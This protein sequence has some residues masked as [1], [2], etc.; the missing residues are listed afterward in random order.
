MKKRLL[1]GTLLAFAMLLFC[2][3]KSSAQI[4][5][6]DVTYFQDSSNNTGCYYNQVMD[7]GF[8]GNII[9][10]AGLNDSVDID[11]NWGDGSNTYMRLPLV[12]S[13]YFYS[14]PTHTFA[15]AGT[16]TPQV[17]ATFGT[18]SDFE[19]ANT[20]TL[21][22][23]CASLTGHLYMDVNSNCA[24]DAGEASLAWQNIMITNTTNSDVYYAYTDG[25][26]DY[27]VSVPSGITYTLIPASYYALTTTC[28]SSGTATVTVATGMSYNNDFGMDCSTIAGTDVG[29]DGWAWNWR[30]GFDR[31]LN[32]SAWSNNWCLSVPATVTLTL[33]PMLS[34]T[35]LVGAWPGN[36]A[37]SSVSGSTVTWNLTS[38]SALSQL[39]SSMYIYCDPSATLGD[40]LCVTL[41]ITTSPADADPTNNTVVICAPVNNSMDP[42]EKGVSPK[43]LQSAGYIDNGTRLTYVVD[44]QNTGNDVAYNVI[45]KDVI[46]SD[47]DISTLKIMNTSHSMLQP[48]MLPNNEMA[49]VFSGINLPDSGANEP[50]SHGFVVYSIMPKAGLAIGTQIQNTANIYFDTNPAIVTNSTLNTIGIPNGIQHVSN[51]ELKAS[52][53][54]N[55]ASGNVYMEVDGKS[56]FRAELYDM[57]GRNVMSTDG[58]DGRSVMNVQGLSNGMYLMKLTSE[59]NKVISATI[60]V[61][62]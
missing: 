20:I 58:K 3:T 39:W 7:F 21:T 14:F 17:T 19:L 41:T 35:S 18:Y 48:T 5:G 9:G 34:Y 46:D 40:T 45:I 24:I 12:Q 44:F 23:A 25:N 33:D 61:S 26:G 37:P 52:I 62:H 49:F 11:I 59:D 29:V 2:N 36:T 51:G 50:A 57:I 27:A 60:N 6:I 54:P 38:L 13:N 8:G 31:A 43:G 28:P 4:T 53:F 16:F 10:T 15:F 1:A 42:N 30:P 47:L 55:P 32:I 22:N 56:N